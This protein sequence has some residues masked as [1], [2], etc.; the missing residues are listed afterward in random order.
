MSQPKFVPFDASK[1]A[2]GSPFLARAKGVEGKVVIN[3]FGQLLCAD[4]RQMLTW[5]P[6]EMEE[7]AKP[8]AKPE[9]T[10]S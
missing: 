7:P 5:T 6:E 3:Q 8:A 4:K 10:K 2:V 1:Q 9:E